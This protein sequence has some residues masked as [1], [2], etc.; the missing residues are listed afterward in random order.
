MEEKS[1][2]Q[3]TDEFT[4]F[5][6]KLKE[7]HLVITPI[8]SR[9]LLNEETYFRQHGKCKLV[10]CEC[11]RRLC[12]VLDQY[13]TII[14]DE[15]SAKFQEKFNMVSILNDANH[16]LYSHSTEFENI[17]KIL[18]EESSDK[19]P[20]SLPNCLMMRRNYRERSMITS[21]EN[22]LHSLYAGNDHVT[23]VTQ[24]ILDSLHCNYFHT[25]DIGYKLTEL[26]KQKIV[27]DDI[28][29]DDA[30]IEDGDDANVEKISSV[31]T[32]KREQNKNVQGL[33]RLKNDKNKFMVQT[34]QNKFDV[35]SY[36]YRYFYWNHY[37]N[38]QKPYDDAHNLA[39][40][41]SY[42]RD[43]PTAN[44]GCSVGDWYVDRKYENFKTELTNNG[45]RGIGSVQWNVFTGKAKHHMRTNYVKAIRCPRKESAAYYEMKED[46][47]MTEDH[48]ISMM[49][50]CNCDRL[51]FA[52]S[53][54]YRHNDETESD[55]QMLQRHRNYYFLGRLLREC[56]E[57]FGMEKKN[58]QLYDEIRLYQGVD[59]QFIFSSMFAYIK[60]PFSATT[61]F[62]VAHNF[63]GGKGM[64]LDL[65][66][67][68]N[69]WAFKKN[70]GGACTLRK[71]CLDMNWISDYRNENEIF[72][73][74]G[75]NKFNFN[76]II[77]ALN[78]TNYDLYIKGIKQMTFCMQKSFI[79]NS[80]AKTEREKKWFSFSWH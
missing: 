35:F 1:L 59:R 36:G 14:N 75:L 28:K 18:V 53:E 72:T 19:K 52:F 38:N 11:L 44:F 77:D 80:M 60:G 17:Y 65:A 48:L 15:K 3:N 27:N 40:F 7:Q 56:V 46:D 16:L 41:N 42:T 63:C 69:D 45:I 43:P 49:V 47:M 66:I 6:K 24:Q 12:Q 29:I 2:T 21:K 5:A 71:T 30:E 67:V 61:S 39:N 50:Y 55:G 13:H 34:Q 9:Y 37:K 31:L 32:A 58:P 78:G 25:F 26:E 73:I 33:E 10:D 51:Q 62:A 64:I 74:G 68:T 23:Q 22:L 57:C 70:E 79:L 76:T 8:E 4:L 20:C 54:T